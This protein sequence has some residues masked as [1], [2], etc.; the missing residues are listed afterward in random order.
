[1]KV[2]NVRTFKILISFNYLLYYLLADSDSTEDDDEESDKQSINVSNVHKATEQTILT[3]SPTSTIPSLIAPPPAIKLPSGPPPPPVGMPPALL[4]RPPPL[5]PNMSNL[6]I[7]MPPGPPPGRPGV[8]PGPPPGMPPRLGIRMPP[9]PP[10]GMP[11]NRLHHNHHNKPSQ[12]L[13][14]A[15]G[16][17]LSAQP[18]L[19][20]KGPTITAKPQI[21]YDFY[22]HYIVKQ[23]VYI[24]CFQFI[25]YVYFFIIGI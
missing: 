18:L 14:P 12:Q 22:F 19:T 4:F 8:P 6:S 16:N 9:G 17:T 25:V 15:G 7:R 21:R 23:N 20:A 2:M 24:K 13:G 11:P 5:R 10:P 1:M 3:A